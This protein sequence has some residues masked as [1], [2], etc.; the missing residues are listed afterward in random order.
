MVRHDA[1]GNVPFVF[2]LI[3]LARQLAD[4]VSE[5]LN[6]VHVKNG[7]HILHHRGQTLQTHAR[8][9]VLLDQVSVVAVSVIVELGE[10]VVPHLDITVAVAAHRTA[11]L[12]AAVLLAA[13]IVYLG[14]G[15]AGAGAVLPEIVLFSETEDPL[16]RDADLLIPDIE[17]LVVVQ[18]YGRIQSVRVQSDHLG[19]KLPAPGDRLMLEIIS[20][21]EISQ[22]LKESAVPV[23]LSDILDIARADALLTG[24]HSPSGRDLLPG[25][26][27]FQGSHA[28]IDQQ[29]AVVVV[30]HQGKALHHQMPLALKKVQEHLPQF[31]Y[32]VFFH[33]FILQNCLNLS[34]YNYNHFPCQ[35]PRRRAAKA[36]PGADRGNTP[37]ARQHR[38]ANT[39]RTESTS[40]PT[41]PFL[42]SSRVICLLCS[43]VRRLSSFSSFR[44]CVR[45][46]RVAHS[47]CR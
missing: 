42:Q 45:Y 43:M 4:P 20:E 38:G 23:G 29:Q 30:R 40:P 6:G 14:A 8:I 32:T 17:G 41:M 33:V 1:D 7:I 10:H 27:G 5:R 19:Q 26:I 35:R 47:K 39:R 25:K 31:V 2:F 9:D 28:R 34:H 13:V 24:G 18:I 21:G 3:G 22:H 15:A 37:A 16:R 12:S 11:G 44:P 46:R 36:R